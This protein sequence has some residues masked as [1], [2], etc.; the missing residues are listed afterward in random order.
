MELDVLELLGVAAG[1]IAAAL[2]IRHVQGP[3]A[4]DLIVVTLAV[5]PFIARA[6]RRRSRRP[7]P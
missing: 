6:A 1:L 5:G 2:F 3:L 4:L 7:R